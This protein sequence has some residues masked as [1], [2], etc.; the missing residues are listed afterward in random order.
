MSVDSV[1]LDL[2]FNSCPDMLG[3][4]GADGK[5]VRVNKAFSNLLGWTIEDFYFWPLL[6]FVHAD[7]VEK[8]KRELGFVAKEKMVVFE[9]RLKKKTEGFVWFEWKIWIGEDGL[10]YALARDVT[11]RRLNE[12]F[13]ELSNIDLQRF[14]MAV[15]YAS[16]II[17]INDANGAIVYAN[18]AFEEVTGYRVSEIIGTKGGQVWGSMMGVAFYEALWKKMIGEKRSYSG[19]IQDTKKNGQEYVA[20]LHISPIYGSKGELVYFVAIERDITRQKEIDQMKTDFLSLASHQLR[21]PLTAMRWLTEL[22]VTDKSL[23]EKQKEITARVASANLRMIN[24]VNTLLNISRIQSGR[25]LITIADTDLRQL[26][27]EVI[28][29]VTPKYGKNHTITV[30]VADEIG[31]LRLDAGLLRHVYMNLLT[32]A[33]KYSDENS[34]VI[35]RVYKKEEVIVSEVEDHGVGIPID[36]QN[37]VFQRFFRADNVSGV[38]TDG[39]GLG[40]YLV[41]MIVQACGGKISFK[42]EQGVGTTFMFTLPAG[43]MFERKGEVSLE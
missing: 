30:R 1:S 10:L 26:I 16:D 3:V 31:V 29:D 25:I 41:Q 34:E 36:Q 33:L 24:L 21:T 11:E 39:T 28:E 5:F 13:L 23:N 15:E 19:E 7:D 37:K 9:N 6:W 17:I 42:S 18:H 14:R 22:L 38:V 4:V 35:V 12:E 27:S 2:F 8:T 32:N 20:E 40:L 43:G